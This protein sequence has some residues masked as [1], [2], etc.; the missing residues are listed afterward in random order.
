MVTWNLPET[1]E[2]TEAMLAYT[3]KRSSIRRWGALRRTVLGRASLLAAVS[4]LTTGLAIAEPVVAA[5]PHAR[6]THAEHS[7]GERSE[8]RRGERR[9]PRTV[10][11]TF[12]SSTPMIITDLAP[13]TL[14]PSVI[15]VSNF[16][17]GST[18][19]DVNVV[20]HGF[21]HTFADDVD[22]MLMAPDGSSTILM[23]DVGDPSSSTGL[24]LTI[25]DQAATPLPD[26]GPLAAGSFQPANY[27]GPESFPAVSAP[28]PSARLARL[29][30][31]NPNGEWR[32]YV[33]DDE[34][35]FSGELSGWVLQ[36]WTQREDSRRRDRR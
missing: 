26:G 32:L 5:R 30:G 29:N 31:G 21:T 4:C 18:V 36:L 10:V 22:I 11:R 27:G 16:R 7:P 35:S 13:S 3:A 17:R 9:A 8:R 2:G 28:S 33:V 34:G 19:T 12:T 6:E 20:L 24:S 1:Q 14:Y 15:Q 23:S 25:D